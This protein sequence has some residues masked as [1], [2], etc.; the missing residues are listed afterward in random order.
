MNIHVAMMRSTCK[1]EGGGLVGTGFLVGKP[2]S[3]QPVRL[4]YTLVTA[5][6]VLAE[7]R[8]NTTVMVFRRPKDDEEWERVEVPLRI[9]DGD[10]DLWQKHVD[11]D[12]AAMHVRLPEGAVPGLLPMEFLVDD[13]KIRRFEMGPGTELLCLG[14]PFGVEGTPEGFPILRSGKIAS[15]PLLPTKKRKTF[16]FD[17]TVF[18]GNSGGPVYWHER[19][20]SF[21]G[22]T[23]IGSFQGIMGVVT[24]QTLFPQSVQLVYERREIRTPLALGEVIHASFI[25]E[26]VD[27]LPEP[28]DEDR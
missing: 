7:T 27:S 13:E 15:Y 6:H 24:R 18:P 21:G 23:L 12:L 17:F 1:I 2:I 26:L 4:R 9:R 14:Y 10:R 3:K 20:P 28:K 25:R 16:L 8:G 11:V 19:N 5:H 22:G